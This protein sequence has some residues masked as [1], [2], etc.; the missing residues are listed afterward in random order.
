MLHVT[1]RTLHQTHILDIIVG[2][3]IYSSKRIYHIY[4]SPLVTVAY[5]C[6][7]SHKIAMLIIY[8]NYTAC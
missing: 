7:A 8:L 1:I 5:V 3:R 6:L 4:I 2:T